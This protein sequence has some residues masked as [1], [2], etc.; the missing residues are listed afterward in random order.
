M[1]NEETGIQNQFKIKDVI[2]IDPIQIKYSKYAH[3]LDKI[4]KNQCLESF[5]FNMKHPKKYT[6]KEFEPNYNGKGENYDMYLIKIYY[7]G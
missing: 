2:D 6:A 7:Q 5:K 4:F 1:S 3:S